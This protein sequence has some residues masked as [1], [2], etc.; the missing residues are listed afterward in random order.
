MVKW[1]VFMKESQKSRACQAF[2]HKTQEKNKHLIII[3]AKILPQLMTGQYYH[4]GYQEAY[5]NI[6]EA[7]GNSGR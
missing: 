6:K 2:F 7:T 4:G 5:N 1:Q 3:I